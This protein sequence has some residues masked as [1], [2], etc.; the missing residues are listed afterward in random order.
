MENSILSEYVTER[1]KELDVT[2]HQDALKELLHPGLSNL[3]YLCEE[4]IDQNR[5]T[6][7][8]RDGETN[9]VRGSSESKNILLDIIRYEPKAGE[10]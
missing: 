8:P 1:F 3:F 10:K 9:T 5:T 2:R 6:Y 4:M 7:C